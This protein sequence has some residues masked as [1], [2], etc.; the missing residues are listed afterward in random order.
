[1]KHDRDGGHIYKTVNLDSLLN[2]QHG[3]LE[4]ILKNLIQALREKEME[5]RQQ[6][7]E[8]KLEDLFSYDIKFFIHKVFESIPGTS[9]KPWE[10]GGGSIRSFIDTV[11]KLKSALKKRAATGTYEWV[12]YQISEIEYPLTYLREYFEKHGE[13]KLNDEDANIFT[14]FVGRKLLE[15][16]DRVREIDIEYSTDP[17]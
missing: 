17:E 12:E 13:G 9:A 5:H 10:F 14:D 2:I 4:K 11:D 8:E 7:R 1:M 3:Q 16:K 15:L 6:F